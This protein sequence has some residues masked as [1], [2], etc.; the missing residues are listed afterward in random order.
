MQKGNFNIHIKDFLLFRKSTDE[1]K[2]IIK[3]ISKIIGEKE[4]NNFLDIGAG[5]G[6]LTKAIV[7]QFNIKNTI[8]IDRNIFDKRMDK[9]IVFLKKDWSN[10]TYPK[11]FDFILSAHSIAYLSYQQ[12]EEAIKKIYD[13]LEKDGVA[14][15]IVYDNKGNWPAF[16]KIFYPKYKLKKC[17][18]DCIRPIISK[19]NFIEKNF[20]SRIYAKNLRQMMKIGRFLGEKHLSSYLKRKE[21]IST[22]F[23]KFQRRDKT[24]VFPLRHKLFVLYK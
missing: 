11:K 19:Y 17:T 23:K 21:E 8:A 2:I 16:K 4:I 13:Y 14:I 24:I 5:T 7:Q 22:F 3:E 6:E 15:I 12:A 20:I 18:L 9:N 10:F 1:V